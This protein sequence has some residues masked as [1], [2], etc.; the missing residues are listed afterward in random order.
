VGASSDP[1]VGEVGFQRVGGDVIIRGHVGPTPDYV[2][3]F[4]EIELDRFR[5]TPETGDFIF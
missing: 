2:A 4:F 3:G 5:G 1:G